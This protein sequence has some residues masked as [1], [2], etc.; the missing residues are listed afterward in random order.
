M[1]WHCRTLTRNN[2]VNVSAN[3]CDRRVTLCPCVLFEQASQEREAELADELALLNDELT[4][5][6]AVAARATVREI[7]GGAKDEGVVPIKMHLEEVTPLHTI[8][9]TRYYLVV[10]TVAWSNSLSDHYNNMHKT[11]AH[12]GSTYK[13]RP[14]HLLSLAALVVPILND[15][16]QQSASR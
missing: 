13:E 4:R 7:A 12:T 14:L 10:T 6:R 5:V 16:P 1:D 11:R 8:C 3:A 9:H 2:E 15:V